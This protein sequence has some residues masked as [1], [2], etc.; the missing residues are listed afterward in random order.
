MNKPPPS[1]LPP[2][3]THKFEGYAWYSR[4]GPAVL[5]NSLDVN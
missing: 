2:P 5:V 1:S 3:F 4:T